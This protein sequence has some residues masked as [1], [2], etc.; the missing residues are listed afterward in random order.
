MERSG[1]NRFLYR[2]PKGAYFV[3]T[4]T[5]W[6]GEADTLEPISQQ[7]AIELYE[8]SLTEHAVEYGEAFPEVTVEDA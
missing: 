1:R 7:E 3:V 8:N 6:Q 2:T 4:L 5:Q